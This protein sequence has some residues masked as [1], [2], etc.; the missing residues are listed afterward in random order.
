MA[1]IRSQG[2]LF[3]HRT[4][5]IASTNY[6]LRSPGFWTK[7]VQT[8]NKLE[9][10]DFLQIAN[11]ATNKTSAT[12]WDCKKRFLGKN[13]R[14]RRIE[15]LKQKKSSFSSGQDE[16]DRVNQRAKTH[17]D[18]R[19]ERAIPAKLTNMSD[20]KRRR[21]MSKTVGNIKRSIQPPLRLL[22][23]CPEGDPKRS[24]F[25]KNADLLMPYPDLDKAKNRERLRCRWA[26]VILLKFPCRPY[27]NQNMPIDAEGT[28]EAE[29]GVKKK[30]FLCTSRS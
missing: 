6:G 28:K 17:S 13:N 26:A 8:A 20:G 29:T 5:H 22:F 23:P 24:V 7:K 16:I 2:L 21:S 25:K 9:A 19:E 1:I 30:L 18:K 15:I 27:L 12:E 10:N 4:S 11:G 14:A 3:H